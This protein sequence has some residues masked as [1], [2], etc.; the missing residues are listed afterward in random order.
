VRLLAL[1]QQL[2]VYKRKSKKPL[3]RNRDRLF[4][5]MLG[6]GGVEAVRLP[7]R[8]PNLSAHIERFMRSVK[9]VCLHR[10][11]FFGEAALVTAVREFISHF[12]EERNHQGLGNRLIE[13]G[14]EV[15]R[16]AGDVVCRERL[17]R[18]LRYYYR[19][20]A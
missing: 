16:T 10:L 20:A 3:L 1:R 11:I 4:R 15:G 17:G 7:P 8:S 2:A 14:R 9:E 13:P 5:V 19:E 6:Q 18:L 12:H